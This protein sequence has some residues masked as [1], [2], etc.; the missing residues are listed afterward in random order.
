[1]TTTLGSTDLEIHPLCL[2]GNVFGWTADEETSFAVLD[3]YAA[4]GGNF[5]DTANQYSYWAP[6][7]SGGE[8]ETILG[9]WM[10]ARANR[11]DVVVAT[12]VGGPMPG[13]PHD[14][15]AS[16]IHRAVDES[17]AR[18]Q[19][20]R[21]DLYYAHFD[22]ASTPLE[23]TLQAYTELVQ[24]GKVRHLAASNYSAERLAEALAISAELG[25]EP[26]KVL[27]PHYNLVERG[28]EARLAPLCEEHAIPALPYFSLA[29]GFLT[30]KY[31]GAAPTGD[32]PRAEAAAEY[33]GERG[34]AVLAALDDIAAAH[35]TSVATVA[36]A[37]LA[38]K[39][40]VAAPIASARNLEQLADLLAV[41]DVQ[42][43]AAEVQRL[44]A[45]GA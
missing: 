21:I 22:D 43:S 19:T 17:L 16:T 18:L 23:E 2:G 27:Q 10:K 8:S 29:K 44:D 37:W 6:G 42:L 32:S 30:G 14:L 5:V 31:R 45:A 25:L 11:D 4:A 26:F 28:F 36:L 15:R 41:A 40:L 3:A 1:M 13:L 39:P 34:A 38:A 35:E 7:N 12:K 33:A 20:D 9:N 24:A